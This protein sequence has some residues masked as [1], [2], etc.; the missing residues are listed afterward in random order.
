MDLGALALPEAGRQRGDPAHEHPARPVIDQPIVDLRP[1]STVVRLGGSGL[2][3]G[4][5]R[6]GGV[7]QEVGDVAVAVERFVSRLPAEPFEECRPACFEAGPVLD[8]AIQGGDAGVL[9][10]MVLL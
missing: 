3:L 1:P 2:D 5:E 8:A 7:H 10:V 9:V 6:L 4:Q